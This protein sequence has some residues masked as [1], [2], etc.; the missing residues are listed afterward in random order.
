MLQY[1]HVLQTKLIPKYMRVRKKEKKNKFKF[2]TNEKI[3][4]K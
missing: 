1:P 2:I 4:L 3:D